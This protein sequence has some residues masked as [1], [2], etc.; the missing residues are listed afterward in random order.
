M[1][2]PLLDTLQGGIDIF[3]IGIDSSGQE[4]L[5]SS[6]YGGSGDDF[7]Q[8]TALTADGKVIFVGRTYSANFP[9]LA[10]LYGA[11]SQCPSQSQGFVVAVSKMSGSLLFSTF[12]G[13]QAG[14]NEVSSVT[15]DVSGNLLLAGWTSAA[16][17][18]LMQSL[19]GQLEGGRDGFVVGVAGNGA[20]ISLATYWGGA[21]DEQATAIASAGRTVIFA[22]STYSN[23]F[24]L[25]SPL[26]LHHGGGPWD[27][28]VTRLDLA[29]QSQCGDFDAS[30]DI[31]V[32]DVVYF[33]QYVFASGSA[34][35]DSRQGDIDCDGGPTIADAVYLINYI[36]ADGPPP[37]AGCR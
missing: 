4:P 2:Q 31:N 24:P 15:S 13:G 7:A 29:D 17:F 3:C 28:F 12:L 5:W 18:P 1:W 9:V 34:P 35:L 14:D 11:C 6:Y 33:V 19:Q 20:S 25:Q 37:C 10:P 21:S 27:G 22:G 16:D 26:Q 23:G 8:A 30:A 36:F 32:A